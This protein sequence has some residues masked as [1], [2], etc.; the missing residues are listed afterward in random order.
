MPIHIVLNDTDVK[1]THRCYNL[2]FKLLNYTIIIILNYYA[3]T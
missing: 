3:I 2:L 1:Y